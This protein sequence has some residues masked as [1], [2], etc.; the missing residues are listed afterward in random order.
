[1]QAEK[2][3]EVVVAVLVFLLLLL[4]VV[5][6]AV[7]VVLEE[8]VVV[9]RGGVFITLRKL[10]PLC[11]LKDDDDLGEAIVADTDMNDVDDADAFGVAVVVDDDDDN[12]PFSN[13]VVVAVAIVAAV[14]LL[15]SF[16]PR[17]DDDRE[18]KDRINR[19][20]RLGDF[21]TGCSGDIRKEDNDFI[22]DLLL[23]LL[24]LLM[25]LIVLLLLVVLCLL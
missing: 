16:H 8:T 21:I 12:A 20:D 6:E 3:V 5:V 24:L 13:A 11:T 15:S 2:V 17:S 10:L 14:A 19:G 23:L 1:M 9:L 4:L 25:L 7:G 22:R 18:N